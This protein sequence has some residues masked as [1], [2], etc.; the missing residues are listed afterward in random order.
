VAR[1]ESDFT[2]LGGATDTAGG[3]FWIPGGIG[4]NAGSASGLLQYFA[5]SSGATTTLQNL[6]ASQNP[7]YP[8]LASSASAVRVVSACMQVF[9]AGSENSRAG[10]ISYG[11]TTGAQVII[12]GS[13]SADGISQVFPNVTRTPMDH[14]EIKLRPTAADQDWTQPSLPTLQPDLNRKGAIG[15]TV[16]GI[17][18]ST[19]IRVR[20]VA[21]YEWQPLANQGLVT[22]DNARNTSVNTLDHVVNFLDRTGNWVIRAAHAANTVYQ[23]GRRVQPYVSQFGHTTNYGNTRIPAMLI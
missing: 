15:F 8:F 17:P 14:I 2:I 21:V 12:G 11:G 7:G 3:I 6:P 20:L 9:W 1:F 5:A 10:Y 23:V 16:K 22:P 19:G 18:S 13:Y 4:S